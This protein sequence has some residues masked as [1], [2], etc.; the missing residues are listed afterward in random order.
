MINENELPSHKAYRETLNL[1]NERRQ[2]SVR[3][4]S[5][6]KMDIHYKNSKQ[7]STGQGLEV[8]ERDGGMDTWS[9][10]NL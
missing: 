9:T 2:L 8:V 1:I 3:S 5:E 6:K 4:Y 7:I 10:G